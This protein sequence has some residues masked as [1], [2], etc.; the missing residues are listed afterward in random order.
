MPF[1]KEKSFEGFF[2]IKNMSQRTSSTKCT[3]IR[4]AQSSQCQAAQRLEHVTGSDKSV[5]ESPVG[6]RS[7]HFMEFVEYGELVRSFF[8][9]NLY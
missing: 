4:R 8:L 2:S 3:F 1:Q 6:N 9:G 5:G 7:R